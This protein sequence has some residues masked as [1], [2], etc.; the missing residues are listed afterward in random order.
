MIFSLNQQQVCVC[1]CARISVSEV[2]YFRGSVFVDVTPYLAMIPSQQALS[3]S[4]PPAPRYQRSQFRIFSR[5]GKRYSE[6]LLAGLCDL[7]LKTHN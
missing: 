6:L 7:L 2:S 3:H 5:R 4:L 1:V